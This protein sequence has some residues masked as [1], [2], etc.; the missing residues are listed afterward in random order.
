MN[1]NGLG[2]LIRIVVIENDDAS[3][4]VCMYIHIYIR[5]LSA[6]AR[7]SRAVNLGCPRKGD[8]SLIYF[9]IEYRPSEGK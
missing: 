8:A 7:K 6:S 4:N 2:F 9:S 3:P 5:G 1:D